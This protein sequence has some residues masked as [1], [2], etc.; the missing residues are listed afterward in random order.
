MQNGYS[1]QFGV[2]RTINTTMDGIEQSREFMTMPNSD[3]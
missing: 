1:D 2:V 3:D